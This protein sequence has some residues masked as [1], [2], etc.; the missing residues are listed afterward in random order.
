M[1]VSDGWG[2][3]VMEGGREGVHTHIEMPSLKVVTRSA[4]L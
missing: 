1:K 3:G 4:A 2:E